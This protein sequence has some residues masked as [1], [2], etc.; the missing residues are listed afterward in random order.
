M[1]TFKLLTAGLAIITL[2]FTSCKKEEETQ[3]ETANLTLAKTSLTLKVGEYEKVAIKTGNGTYTATSS[4]ITKATVT[5]VN[6][7]LT[8]TALA[9]GLAT[10][11][12]SDA[13]NHTADISVKV[14]DLVVPGEHITLLKGNTATRTIS[15]GNDYKVATTDAAIATATI[16]NNLLTIEAISKGNALVTVKDL[17]SEKV[18]TFSVTVESQPLALSVATVALTKGEKVAVAIVSGNGSYTVSVADTAVAAATVSGTTVTV[19]GVGVGTT[20]ITVKD[21]DDKTAELSV[22]VNALS[23]ALEK[24]TVEVNADAAVEVAIRSGN[25]DYTAQVADNSKATATI[26][27][28]KVRIEGKAAGTTKVTVKDS[29]N[30]TAEIIVTVKPRGLSLERTALTINAGTTAEVAIFSGNGG[31]TV[32]V[33]DN[34]K[35]TA[36]VVNNKVR[37]EAKAAGTTKV[38]V[39]DSQNKT[40]E[41][42]V[43]VNA[44]SLTLERNA[45]EVNADAAVEV[46]I[47]AGNGNYTLQVADNSKA[48]AT[49]VGDKVRI[50]GKAAGTTKVTVKDSQNKTAEITVTVK[51]RGLSLERTAL[52]INAGT[53]AEV[54]IFSGNGGYTVQVADNSKVTASVV[55]NKVRIEGKAAGTTK[56]IVKDNQNKTAEITVNVNAFSLTLERNAVELNPDDTAE[57][58]I[59]NGNGNYTLQVAD[60]S[61]AIATIVGNKVRIE[62]KAAG[63]TKVTVKDSQNKTAE[64]T[65][66]V[67]ARAL[68]LERTAL[69]INAGTTAEVAIFSG[70]GGYTVQVAD[71]S[72]VTASVVN[73]KVRI[74]GKAAGTTK[75]T[76]KDGQNKT[77]EITVTVNAFSLTLERNAVELN[78]DDT[79]EVSITNGNGNYTLQVADNS[80]VTATIVGNKVRIEGKAAGTTKVTV[81]DSQNKT[82]E[83]T[84]TIRARALTLE[85]TTL[86]INAGT[87]AEVAITA[88]NDNYTLQVADNSKATAT[89]VGNKVRIEGKAAGTTKVTVK[90]SQNK[91]A[92]ITVTINPF[93]LSLERNALT[94]NAGTTAEVAIFSGN[95]GYTVQVADNSKVTASVVNNKVRI[96]AKAAGTTKVTVKDSQNK[97]AEISVT[98]SPRNLTVE[99]M[100]VELNAGANTL[101]A[102]TNGNGGYTAVSEDNNKVTAQI[103]GNGIRITAKAAGTAKVTVKDSANKQVEIVVV[104]K[105]YNLTVDKTEVEVNV[106]AT[107]EVAI[108]SGNG[109]YSAPMYD[110][111]KVQVAIVGSTVRIT[112]KAAGETS[113]TVKD[114]Q[115]K[116]V[117][118]IVTVKG[119][120]LEL[121]KANVEVNV[122][123]T[124]EVAI[125]K[126]TAPYT[127]S[128]I[129]SSVATAQII[130]GNKVRITGVGAGTTKVTVGDD[131]AKQAFIMVTVKAVSTDDLFD[132]VE[133]EDIEEEDYKNERVIEVKGSASAISGN[134][135]LPARGTVLA[136]NTLEYSSVSSVDFN[137]V[138]IIGEGALHSSRNLTKV[139]L[140]KVTKIKSM[141]FAECDKLKEVRCNMNVPPTVESDAFDGIAEDAVLWVPRGKKGAYEDVEAFS[142]SFSEIKEIQ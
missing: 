88:G 117:E 89:I 4:D 123:A 61:K 47:T 41:I 39:K 107:A 38:T 63:T 32:Q 108:R 52:T 94:I 130:G 132:I 17:V 1:K 126:G 31:Y 19:T 96:E 79:A 136:D 138:K 43:T 105:P 16:A 91:T 44:F 27:G 135:V 90:D 118:I 42:T 29:Q 6:N 76:V 113:V 50:E 14:L 121:A 59:T 9:E 75:V 86:T 15:F 67:R 68:T 77:A 102:I 30:K 45:V 26:V 85:R 84:V 98:V 119:T 53:T 110:D 78:P 24:T 81:K 129:N 95:S 33:A 22:T 65:V 133:G 12:V 137:N 114:S 134:I 54:A 18:Q 74:E 93:N 55:N 3:D 51:P 140:K 66:T 111:T 103:E 34:S 127:V 82:A 120:D 128:V 141:A 58:S 142:S 70:N 60:N 64:I 131:Q 83:I 40:A 8:I 2:L 5:L 124:A 11:T 71:N 125:V 99:K 80:K 28:D 115:D 48:T 21:A 116:T 112:G 35:V 139:L 10:V 92:E 109:G 62:G 13:K 101:V 73:N 100:R 97:T 57:V 72:K 23:L 7:E 46:A 69:T 104:V 122:G 20:K 36:S 106:G 25:G 56:V 87:T 49:I 37:I